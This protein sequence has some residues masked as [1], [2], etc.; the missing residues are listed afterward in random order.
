MQYFNLGLLCLLIIT[1]CNQEKTPSPPSSDNEIIIA[2]RDS[3]YSTILGEQRN[4]YI[5]VPRE[6]NLGYPETDYPVLF[7]LDAESH[8]LSIVG[9]LDRMSTNIG[10][11]LCP[12]MMVVGISNTDRVRDMFPIEDEDKFHEFLEK[13]LIPYIDKKYPTQPYRVLYGHSITGLRTTHTAIFYPDL[14]NAYI[15]IDPSLC[16]QYCGW[17]TKEAKAIKTFELPKNQRF[18]LA[19]ANTMDGKDTTE[20]KQD[21]S[22]RA[23]HMNAMMTFSNQMMA[24]NNEF[25]PQFGWQYY[26]D[27][28][29]NSVT[30]RATL[31]G[32]EH[33]FAWYKN[34]S[35]DQIFDEEADAETAFTVYQTHYK[36]VSEILGYELK[37][38][39]QQVSTL[40]WYLVHIKNMNKKALLFAQ[41]NVKNYP[42]SEHAKNQLEE[43]KASLK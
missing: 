17:F 22:G 32:L 29:H 10:E 35:Y 36:N 11:E 24:K 1:S 13:E 8:F 3:L 28:S 41:L 21:T 4:L 2:K 33:I 34:D 15:A 6:F 27:E 23:S 30:L 31:D 9:M 43:V 19:M 18:F 20:V 39:E 25:I 5:H 14:F 12:Q 38:P 26:P 7:V 37:P 42:N 16:H 40:I